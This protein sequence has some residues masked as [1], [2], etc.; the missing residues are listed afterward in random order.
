ME[1]FF[2]VKKLSIHDSIAYKNALNY[3]GIKEINSMGKHTLKNQIQIQQ[4]K[5][6]KIQPLCVCMEE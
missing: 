4:N 5:A 3:T 6:S 1:D 2:V